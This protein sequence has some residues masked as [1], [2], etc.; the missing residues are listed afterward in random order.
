MNYPDNITVLIIKLVE[1]VLNV[2]SLLIFIRA[3]LSW[4]TSN[5]NN[6]LNYFLI[7]ITEPV[8]APIRRL[9]PL[10]GIDF[11]PM[12]AILLINVVI[13]PIIRYLLIVL[14]IH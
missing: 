12:I 9:I 6:Q 10:H 4:F 7:R 3:L 1:G 2:Y 8:L 14:L 13:K 5:P 11:S